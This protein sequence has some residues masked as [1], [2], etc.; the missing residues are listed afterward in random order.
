M[1]KS[2]K[3]AIQ[4][5]CLLSSTKCLMYK[6]MFIVMQYLLDLFLKILVTHWYFSMITILTYISDAVVSICVL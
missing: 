6:I 4:P 5:I 3:T 2:V 1:Y